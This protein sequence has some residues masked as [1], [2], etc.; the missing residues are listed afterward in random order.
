MPPQKVAVVGLGRMGKGMLATLAR[1]GLPVIGYDVAAEARE[2]AAAVP[3]A[4]I[5]ADLATIW[6]EAETIVLSLSFP[7]T[8][9]EVLT[10]NGGLV[11]VPVIGRLVIDTSTSDPDLTRTLHTRLQSAGHALVD[12]P[13]SGGPAGAETGTLA[14]M[15]GG[16]AK[17][18]ERAR[19]VLDILGQKIAIVGG[20]GDGHVA[21]LVN[22]VLAAGHLILAGEAM[23]V[24][25][26]AGVAQ[27]ALIS[28]V[29][30]ASGRSAVTEVNYPRWILSGSFDSGF[31][32]G[33]MA[34]DV[35]LA[36]TLAER[37][38]LAIPMLREVRERW[39]TLMQAWGATEDF[40]RAVLGEPE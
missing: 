1:A 2:A 15:V 7:D 14:I 6:R 4:E 27:E 34:K 39:N 20:P 5:T 13:V 9:K 36:L 23:R 29:N 11:S 24:G 12:A 16:T 3:S 32:M 37:T 28:V 22:N 35:S 8:I 17:A 19:P 10:G 21:K 33:L 40:N 25:V 26:A 30:S 38:G 31:T 18:I